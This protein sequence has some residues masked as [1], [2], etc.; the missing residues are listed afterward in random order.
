MEGIKHGWKPSNLKNP[1]SKA[2]ATEMAN[3]DEA[4]KKRKGIKEW[5][6]GH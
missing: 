1:P 6:K 5:L 3:A 2:V 4:K